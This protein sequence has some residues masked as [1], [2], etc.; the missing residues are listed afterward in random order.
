MFVLI[1]R[2]ILVDGSLKAL[3]TK[4][5]KASETKT[6]KVDMFEKISFLFEF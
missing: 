4:E 6:A 3:K 2:T 1:K 5:R